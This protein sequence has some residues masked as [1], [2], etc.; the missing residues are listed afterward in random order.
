MSRSPRDE[1]SRS[2]PREALARSGHRCEAVGPRYGLAEGHRCNGDLGYGFDFDHVL[3]AA[4]GG[5]ASLDNCACVCRV[6]H[7]FKT[8]R[9]ITEIRK[10]DRIRDKHNGTFPRSRHRLRSQGFRKTRHDD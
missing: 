7:K 6:C 2:T 8:A 4:L 9:G 3:E 1:F 10:A 5:D